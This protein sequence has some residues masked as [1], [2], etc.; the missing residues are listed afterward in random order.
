MKLSIPTS[1]LLGLCTWLA[2]TAQA[3]EYLP[4]T[5]FHQQRAMSPAVITQGGRTVWL[6]GQN[7][8]VDAAGKSIKGDFEAQTR[9]V[10]AEID[11]TLKR[12]GGSLRNV[13]SMTVYLRDPRDAEAFTRLRKEAFPD[14]NYPASTLLVLNNLAKPGADV[15]VQAIAV[16][17]GVR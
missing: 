3:A 10:F 1:A 8:I 11:K 12:T 17:E 13:V 14:G 9:T 5:E 6:M 2:A 7:A 16:I 4:G 15:E